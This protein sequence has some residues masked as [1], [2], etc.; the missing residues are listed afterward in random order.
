MRIK[1]IPKAILEFLEIRPEM[2]TKEIAESLR[3][4]HKLYVKRIFI[5]LSKSVVFRA[6]GNYP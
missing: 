6:P 5:Y 4:A 2:T 1:K 3:K